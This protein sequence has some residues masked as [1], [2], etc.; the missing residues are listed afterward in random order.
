M[1]VIKHGKNYVRYAV[2]DCGCEFE[3]DRKD[4]GVFKKQYELGM[5]GHNAIFRK[6]TKEEIK[7]DNN[8]VY[9]VNCPECG[10]NNRVKED[11]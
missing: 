7:K 5:Y 2:C 1:K 8:L 6:A 4:V 11:D 10:K 9:Y 3:Y